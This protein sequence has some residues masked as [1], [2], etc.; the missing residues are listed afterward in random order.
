MKTAD[1]V[2]SLKEIFGSDGNWKRLSKKKSPFKSAW[3][4]AVNVREFEN[5]NDGRRIFHFEEV[6]DSTEVSTASAFYTGGDII[7][8][9]VLDP[10]E[11][12]VTFIIEDKEI[13]DLTGN[14]TELGNF[15]DV[16]R[17][18]DFDRYGMLPREN[19][20]GVDALKFE[21]VMKALAPYTKDDRILDVFANITNTK[22]DDIQKFNG[23]IE[24]KIYYEVVNGSI[25]YFTDS[26]KS[27][28][29]LLPD[30]FWNLVGVDLTLDS[31]TYNYIV[32]ERTLEMHDH[33]I[34]IGGVTSVTNDERVKVIVNT[35]GEANWVAGAQSIS[36]RTTISGKPINVV[37]FTEVASGTKI[38]VL[39]D[40][41]H[42]AA[43]NGVKFSYALN[44]YWDLIL[45]I[46]D[47]VVVNDKKVMSKNL[48][49]FIKH[50]LDNDMNG[51]S[52]KY[53][54]DTNLLIVSNYDAFK[55]IINSPIAVES[56]KLTNVFSKEMFGSVRDSTIDDWNDFFFAE[57]WYFDFDDDDGD[58]IMFHHS[59]ENKDGLMD[60]HVSD[61]FAKRGK[62]L[63]NWLDEVCENMFESDKSK[64]ETIA[65]LEAL[66]FVYSKELLH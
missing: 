3:R 1:I 42:I 45:V 53:H 47:T 10:K 56:R 16:I 4:N 34:E 52:F 5:K 32:N 30:G 64:K 40:G 37:E 21:P 11:C 31:K 23:L 25:K 41:K 38:Q 57:K 55:S 19:G 46:D 12:F 43:W 36:A 18:V 27:Q 39:D 60:Q 20:I 59:P 22:T 58:C 2:N 15:I 14:I 54:E 61:A 65:Q 51:V 44:F 24:N 62:P 66:G 6:S 13:F 7:Y 63:P 35:F 33:F 49:M 48:H 50:M 9:Y 17:E 29:V 28:Q 8:S 26:T